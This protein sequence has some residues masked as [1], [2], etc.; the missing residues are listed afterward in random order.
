MVKGTQQ[1]LHQSLRRKTTTTNLLPKGSALTPTVIATHQDR[2][3]PCNIWEEK[4][5]VD[6][7]IPLIRP[8]Y[9]RKP[10][11]HH[12]QTTQKAHTWPYPASEIAPWH[13]YPNLTPKSPLN[14]VNPTSKWPKITKCYPTP[15]PLE[16][17][18]PKIRTR[19]TP[20]SQQK[21]DYRT[22][23]GLGSHLDRD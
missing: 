5:R 11:F 10:C 17:D 19:S 7:D 12:L 21:D 22:I 8:H 18:A 3:Q 9:S 23:K 2:H 6:T 4:T 14:L 1:D 16:S 15:T 13:R 20:S